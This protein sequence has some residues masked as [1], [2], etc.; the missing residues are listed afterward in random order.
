M[1]YQNYEDYMR[2]VLGYP[3]EVQNTYEAYPRDAMLYENQMFSTI[4]NY[5]DE[6]MNLYPDIYK[7]VHPMVCKIC[8]SNTKPI[9]R[10][11]LDQMTNEIYLNLESI[12]EVDTVVN[13]RVNTQKPI[14]ETNIKESEK[15]RPLQAR[16]NKTS[17]VKG[18]TSL[19]SNI[20]QVERNNK[21]D[22]ENRQRMP[23][24]TLQD[25]IRILILNQLLGINRP[26]RPR[27]PR[28]PFPGPGNPPPRP[29]IPPFPRE[30]RYCN[31]LF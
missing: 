24:R 3:I 4:G 18:P 8:E 23:N 21:E 11:L 12:P 13:V 26:Q 28:P 31:G 6:I 22:S 14:K 1:Y 9:T 29:P 7:L 27:P 16:V 30:D 20:E 5:S 19:N 10:E 25:L 15:N 17:V 2:S